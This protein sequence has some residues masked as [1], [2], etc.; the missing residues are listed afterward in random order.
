MSIVRASTIAVPAISTAAL[1]VAIVETSVAVV[2]PVRTTTL[3]AP[4]AVAAPIVVAVVSVVAAVA[5]RSVA[6]VAAVVVAVA[7]VEALADAGDVKIIV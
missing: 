5:V 1:E 7:E 6:A 2:V 3:L 4:L